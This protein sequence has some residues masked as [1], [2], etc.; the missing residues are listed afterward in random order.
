MGVFDFLKKEVK[1]EFIARPDSSKDLIIY[2]W[3]DTNLRILTQLTV[4]PDEVAVFFK[5]GKVV[6]TLEAGTH[7]LDGAGIPFISGLI[8]AATGGNFLISELYFVSKKQFTNLPFGGMIDNVM[9]PQTKLA[10]TIRLFGEYAMNVNDPSKLIINL[11]GTKSLQTNEQIT[12]WIKELLLKIMRTVVSDDV[13]VKKNPVLGIASRGIEFEKLALEKVVP[14]LTEYGIT[15]VKLGN[16]TVS[17]KE[18]DEATLKQMTRDFAYAGNMQAADAAMKLG[19]A[20]GLQEGSAAGSNASS[21][22][23]TGMGIA[24][25]MN[26]L[27]TDVTQ[28]P[29]ATPTTPVEPAK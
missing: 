29:P 28:T 17:I 16:V 13:S 8:D 20:K 21:A 2:K 18:E 19:M 23:A 10:I 15:I 22:A 1:R 24:M 5:E 25:G 11:V 6:G 7:T 27:K 3:P 26:A 12:E 9:E 14:E 4:Q